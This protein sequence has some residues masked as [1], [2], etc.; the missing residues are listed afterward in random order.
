MLFGI[1]NDEKIKLF[2]EGKIDFASVTGEKRRS[3]M[4]KIQVLQIM[5]V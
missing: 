5:T 4:K 2:D 3:M 1:S